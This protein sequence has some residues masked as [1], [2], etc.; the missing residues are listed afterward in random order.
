M[1]NGMDSQNVT[2]D[3]F[4]ADH[5]IIGDTIHHGTAQG[6]ILLLSEPLSFWG[7]I[8][9]E[10]GEICDTSHPQHGLN[11]KD[12][13]LVMVSGRGSSSSSS[14]LVESVYRR[15][16]PCAIVMQCID[17]ILAIGA[18]VAADLYNIKIPV[19]TVSAQEWLKLANSKFL[20][21]EA[22]DECA[23]IRITQ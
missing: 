22:T 10:S 17:S 6:D 15:T 7:G 3:T 20:S 11:I 14:A 13:I 5:I 4:D 16:A 1:S 18:F 9:L 23:H 21:I 12:R 2:H 8:E 19:V